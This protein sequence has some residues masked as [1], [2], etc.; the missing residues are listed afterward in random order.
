MKDERKK[1]TSGQ[2]FIPRLD[3]KGNVT[4]SREGNIFPENLSA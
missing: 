4:L 1:Q 3:E 2:K